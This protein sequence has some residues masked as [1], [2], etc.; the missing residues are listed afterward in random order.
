[1]TD[2]LSQKVHVGK[3]GYLEDN[4]R[5]IFY[6]VTKPLS[7][8]KP[9]YDTLKSAIDDLKQKCV[10]HGVTKLAMPKIGCGLD[11]LSWHEVKQHLERTFQGS[12][13]DIMVYY[14]NQV[15]DSNRCFTGN[16]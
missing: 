16:G 14:I 1:M 12:E 15:S 6:L 13:I 9:T 4:G 5:Y 10:E 2:L 8:G 7:T 11:R 3:V